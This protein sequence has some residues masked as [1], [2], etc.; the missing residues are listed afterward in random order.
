MSEKYRV[1]PD[2]PNEVVRPLLLE[3]RI[4]SCFALG[5]LEPAEREHTRVPAAVRPD[6]SV[7]AAWVIYEAPG[8]V[9]MVPFGDVDGLR[10]ILKE[11]A[12]PEEPSILH[13]KGHANLIEG[14][15]DVVGPPKQIARMALAS[16]ELQ[17][18]SAPEGFDLDP[19]TASMYSEV[20][21]LYEQWE[22]S[23][24]R[25]ADFRG[26]PMVGAR[27]T[28]GELVAVAAA[29]LER[30]EDRFAIVSGVF[31]RTDY[32]GRGLAKATTSALCERLISIGCDLIS[33]NVILDNAAA[34][35]A[36]RSFGFRDA[37]PYERIMARRVG[38]GR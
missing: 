21:A 19:I 18:V 17:P 2:A 37:I 6:G 23:G 16:G 24:L 5:D 35:R 9:S 12:L 13:R 14:V 28:D 31:T 1:M 7:A 25:A 32:R 4:W 20:D 11:I 33:L 29:L 26:G 10:R 22:G 38:P 34:H 8:D 27:D 36:Y 30:I 3:D 15:F